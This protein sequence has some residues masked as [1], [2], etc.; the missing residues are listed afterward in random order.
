M[1]ATQ[2]TVEV[3]I[4]ALQKF[5]HLGTSLKKL[6]TSPES[7]ILS[8]LKDEVADF[9]DQGC[10]YCV[11]I[12]MNETNISDRSDPYR[13][14]QS[15]LLAAIERTGPRISKDKIIGGII[16]RRKLEQCEAGKT[17]LNYALL[18][19][20]GY[21]PYKMSPLQRKWAKFWAMAKGFPPGRV[22]GMHPGIRPIRYIFRTY[23]YVR[24][25]VDQHMREAVIK[26]YNKYL[27]YVVN[28]PPR[29][30]TPP[31]IYPTRWPRGTAPGGA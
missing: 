11:N 13:P 2:V 3:D 26:F 17:G 9:L 30:P 7:T 16:N 4:K 20:S 23:E 18:L 14:A 19:E 29:V 12:L 25:R 8:D 31:L 27:G 10:Q 15:K 21:G 6:A 22:A 5:L 28:V 24:E 1:I